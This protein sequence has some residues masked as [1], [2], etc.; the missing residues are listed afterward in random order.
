MFDLSKFTIKCRCPKCGELLDKDPNSCSKCGKDSFD[1]TEIMDGRVYVYEDGTVYYSLLEVFLNHPECYIIPGSIKDNSQYQ[2]YDQSN[3]QVQNGTGGAIDIDN[4]SLVKAILLLRGSQ[5]YGQSENGW[6]YIVNAVNNIVINQPLPSRAAFNDAKSG[7]SS[8]LG[9]GG[10]DGFMSLLSSQLESLSNTLRDTD[11]EYA[12]LYGLYADNFLTTFGTGLSAEEMLEK[13]RQFASE[14]DA[15]RDAA[16]ENMDEDKQQEYLRTE[17]DNGRQRHTISEFV[18]SDIAEKIYN[19]EPVTA[20]ERELYDQIVSEIRTTQQYDG[21]GSLT[22]IEKFISYY[23]SAMDS[24]NLVGQY[25]TEFDAAQ[26]ELDEAEAAKTAYLKNAYYISSD[27]LAKYDRAIEEAQRKRDAALSRLEFQR[28]FSDGQQM[29]ILAFTPENQRDDNWYSQFYEYA[30]SRANYEQDQATRRMD[31][32]NE[33]LG[34]M[35][36]RQNEIDLQIFGLNN[37]LRYYSYGSD[38]YNML[39]AQIDA[40]NE[41]KN[42]LS[43]KARELGEEYGAQQSL[44]YAKEFEICSY[45]INR[46]NFSENTGCVISSYTTSTSSDGFSGTS[47]TSYSF[48]DANGKLI[49]DPAQIALYIMQQQRSGVNVDWFGDGTWSYS[50]INPHVQEYIRQFSALPRSA[51]E[52]ET[53]TAI[54]LTCFAYN[55]YDEKTGTFRFDMFNDLGARILGQEAAEANLKRLEGKEGFEKWL[56]V[57]G[58]GILDGIDTW[59]DGLTNLFFA[60]GRASATDYEYQHYLTKV[61]EEGFGRAYQLGSSFGNMLPTIA[62]NAIIGLATGGA[63][64]AAFGLGKLATAA[65]GLLINFAT[66]GLSVM[67]NK[68][69]QLMQ[70]GVNEKTAT[71][72]GFLNGLS[73]TTLE[74][75]LGTIPGVRLLDRFSGLRGIRGYLAKILSEGLEESVQEFIEPYLTAIFT[76][77]DIRTVRMDWAQ[78]REAGIDGMIMAAILNGGSFVMDVT[79]LG[80]T[81][82]VNTFAS[83]VASYQGQ[84]LLDSNV[85]SKMASDIRNVS[86]LETRVSTI[87]KMFE[88]SPEIRSAYDSYL[89]DVSEHNKTAS[90]KEQIKAMDFNEYVTSLAVKQVVNEAR[91]KNAIGKDV[92]KMMGTRQSNLLEVDKLVAE[93]AKLFEQL[94]MDENGNV[95]NETVKN[96]LSESEQLKIHAQIEALNAQISKL[97]SEIKAT[98]DLLYD[99]YLVIAYQLSQLQ[100]GIKNGT[101]KDSQENISKIEQ[102]NAMLGVYNSKMMDVLL[103]KATETV[104]IEKLNDTFNK[105]A[106]QNENI[107][108]KINDLEKQIAKLKEENP[109]NSEINKLIEQKNNLESERKALELRMHDTLDSINAAV[110]SKIADLT[111]ENEFVSEQIKFRENELSELQE[112]LKVLEAQA[113]NLKNQNK[114]KYNKKLKEIEEQRTRIANKIKEINKAKALIEANNNLIDQYKTG[115]FTPVYDFS[116]DLVIDFSSDNTIN[117]DGSDDINFQIEGLELSL[118][119]ILGFVGSDLSSIINGIKS[120]VSDIKNSLFSNL[121]KLSTEQLATFKEKL[122][123]IKEKL[124]ELKIA[125]FDSTISTIDETIDVIDETI[126]SDEII[127][128]IEGLELSLKDILGFAKEDLIKAS[129]NIN[130]VLSKVKDKLGSIKFNFEQFASLRTKLA[131]IKELL[132]LGIENIKSKVSESYKSILDELNKNIEIVDA[133][134]IP[135]ESELTIEERLTRA[136][137][138]EKLRIIIENGI[139]SIDRNVL[140]STISKFSDSQMLQLFQSIDINE[141]SSS[142]LTRMFDSLKD[143]TIAKLCESIKS[144]KVFRNVSD[145][146][147]TEELKFVADVLRRGPSDINVSGK[148]ISV[149]ELLAF[150]FGNGTFDFNSFT[151]SEITYAINQVYTFCKDN[152]LFDN[153]ISLSSKLTSKFGFGPI[154]DVFISEGLLKVLPSTINNVNTFNLFVFIGNCANIRNYQQFTQYLMSLGANNFNLFMEATSQLLNWAKS[155]NITLPNSQYLYQM[156]DAIRLSGRSSNYLQD[157]TIGQAKGEFFFGNDSRGVD[158]GVIRSIMQSGDKSKIDVLVKQVQAKYPGISRKYAEIFLNSIEGDIVIEQEVVDE[159]GVVSKVEKR[160]RGICNYADVS[161]AIFEFFIAHPEL[162]FE[163]HFGFPM[164]AENG[165]FNTSRLLL[166]IYLEITGD[167]F[168]KKGNLMD[169]IK[170]LSKYTAEYI[171]ENYI[172]LNKGVG[173]S[174]KYNNDYIADYLNKRGLGI[175]SI[176]ALEQSQ[177]YSSFNGTNNAKLDSAYIIGSVAKSLSEGKHVSIGTLKGLKM[178]NIS[179]GKVET[180]GE[181]HVMTVIGVAKGKLIVNSWNNVYTISVEDAIRAGIGF[182]ID[183]LSIIPIDQARGAVQQNS[184]I[185]SNT[186]V[187]S[188]ENIPGTSNKLQDAIDRQQSMETPYIE[189]MDDVLKYFGTYANDIISKLNEDQKESIR[190]WCQEYGYKLINNAARSDNVLNKETAKNIKDISDAIKMSQLQYDSLLFRNIDFD[191]LKSSLGLETLNDI[192]LQSLI[193]L[194]YKDKG[195]TATTVSPWDNYELHSEQN[196]F[197][198]LPV[199]IS[200]Y[201]P[202][203]TNALFIDRLSSFEEHE[204]LLDRELEATITDVYKA[205]DEN[206]NE[207]YYITMVFEG[208]GE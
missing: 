179:T 200:I 149:R 163:E 195:F 13:S 148:N 138:D 82:S 80:F 187:Y 207:K 74:S 151:S 108:S 137:I 193:G 69:E 12:Y 32:I 84:N 81:G 140:V 43:Q 55:Y 153:F 171:N 147:L 194:K 5:S 199:E 54:D 17:F 44:A 85:L 121:S 189:D 77:Q 206:G 124:N 174:D 99:N 46:P 68:K 130:K 154:E 37:S 91:A 169:V 56:A 8:L 142:Q 188:T 143:E 132:S 162:S 22:D 50:D 15:H 41:E 202:K 156:I 101:I 167:I 61:S 181:A 36:K 145:L 87:E 168:V 45:D 51:A 111:K 119:D 35:N 204:V 26:S 208:Y 38:A 47:N 160:T 95:I 103:N 18:V 105:L 42:A 79:S 173:N 177:I 107:K 131:S 19:G 123:S 116:S 75:F 89:A 76:G 67:G 78:V 175:G 198:D 170:N 180:V 63:G 25:Q 141:F 185:V 90:K 33:E 122:A 92:L 129:K 98:E 102:L 186:M 88:N 106:E 39:Q 29:T 120:R 30:V 7:L 66:M 126:D 110:E 58:H 150:M 184:N 21:D 6:D 59:G 182:T 117:R 144:N 83:I 155:N 125:K 27:E 73:E 53:D 114:N 96:A 62:V 2:G 23:A 104:S 40:L 196:S 165:Q 4:D 57:N 52:M 100:E 9:G 31:D 65:T 64:L 157:I 28:Y 112:R 24:R 72:I 136:S 176:R 161:N 152:N 201:V 48:Y 134:I 60:D 97:N 34:Q 178:T 93:K 133:I 183:E 158:Q 118:K 10:S 3:D 127:F 191:G 11:E 192:D 164:K 1:T 159:N 70:Q 146:F 94:G 20:E 166:D 86:G 109:L 128:D 16:F 203:G 139:N 172:N 14:V 197:K 49:T 113:N 190:M 115:N 135:I 205:I 71:L